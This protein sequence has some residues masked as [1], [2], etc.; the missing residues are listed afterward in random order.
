MSRHLVAVQARRTG[1]AA[2]TALPVLLESSYVSTLPQIRLSA[3]LVVSAQCFCVISQ[4]MNAQTFR[5]RPTSRQAASA[6]AE[7]GGCAPFSPD[8][9]AVA[10]DRAIYLWDDYSTSVGGSRALVE[11]LLAHPDLRRHARKFDP[12]DRT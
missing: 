9:E 6:E 12:S 1:G 4:T 2:P 10:L 3:S 5:V 7:F 8:A 11:A